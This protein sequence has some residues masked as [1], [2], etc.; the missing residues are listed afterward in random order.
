MGLL[1]IYRMDVLVNFIHLG[2]VTREI[3][4]CY[5]FINCNDENIKNSEN[6]SARYYCFENESIV[7]VNSLW[8]R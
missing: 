6:C 1:K 3:F 4:A 8:I 2:D 5:N 7:V